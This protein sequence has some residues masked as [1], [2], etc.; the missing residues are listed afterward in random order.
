MI[1]ANSKTISNSSPLTT[2]DFSVFYEAIHKFPPFEWQKRL[3]QQVCL[4]SWPGR[5]G[6]T[7]GAHVDQR[8][9][10]GFA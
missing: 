1:Q 5:H 2:D 7:A 4:G 3:A 6:G 9:N 8:R 10:L